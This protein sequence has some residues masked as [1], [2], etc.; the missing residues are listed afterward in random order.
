MYYGHSGVISE[1]YFI[2]LCYV[3]YYG[4]QKFTKFIKIY[5]IYNYLIRK[6][7]NMLP[8]L[9]TVAN[10]CTYVVIDMV[11]VFIIPA[12]SVCIMVIRASLVKYIS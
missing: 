1:I 3:L 10:R 11:S 2:A 4:N 5:K 12:R 6:H 7:V 9:S 8:Q